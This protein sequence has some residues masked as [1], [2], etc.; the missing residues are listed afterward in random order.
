MGL[1]LVWCA[2][3]CSHDMMI[4]WLNCEVVD[5]FALEAFVAG[6]VAHGSGR[7]SWGFS[8]HKI[9]YGKQAICLD[10]SVRQ[11]QKRKF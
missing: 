6:L 7:R 2:D 4:V 5:E 1:A 10:L 3:F 8:P 11:A 9:Y